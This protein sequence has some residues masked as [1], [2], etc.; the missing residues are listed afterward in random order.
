[1]AEE[2]IQIPVK[3]HEFYEMTI[4]GLGHSGEGVGRIKGFTLFV[5]L[6]L[7]S[8]K[9]RVFTEQV[10]KNYAKG[11]LEAILEPSP[12]RQT[13]PCK[14]YEACGGCQL[15]H[16]T[17]EAQLA[18]KQQVVLDAI[19]RIGKLSDVQIHPVLAAPEE[20][21]YRNKMQLPVGRKQ[22]RVVAG[23]YAQGTHAI[24]PI[25]SC[26]IQAKAN[27]Q[28]AAAVRQ[29][30]EELKIPIYDERT[31]EGVVRH[32]M[33]RYAQGTNQLMV[34]LVVTKSDFRGRDKL[35]HVLKADLPQLTSLVL[36]MNSRRTNIILGPRNKVIW[37]KP[38]IEE[39]LGNLTFKISVH[40]FFQVNTAQTEKLY[41][42]ALRYADLTGNETVLDAYCGTGTISLFLAQKAKHVIGIEVVPEAIED[43]KEN[44]KRNQITNAEFVVGDV[45]EVL[46]KLAQ[47][48]LAADVV[49]VDPPRA[50]C[51]AEML[52]TVADMRPKRIVYVSCNPSS[53][54]R[55]LARLEE[56]GYK[57]KEI[58][59]VD[60]FPQTYHVETV[61]LLQ[62]KHTTK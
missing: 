20:F 26:L 60:M 41:E 43:A 36:N 23:C 61:T 3:N 42:V 14:V 35:A 6:A 44:A 50:G 10:K 33:A 28:A 55:D 48:G 29:K 62:R 57:T 59:P 25:E 47:D 24:V 45:T 49:V 39:K 2:K 38:F 37:G 12:E 30:I 7:P 19:Q 40:S 11:R 52:E 34:V 1:M 27:N 51:S 5:P 13:A 54:A 18:A 53:L 17:A 31:G 32:I 21:H 22:G 58:Q 9:V 16:L 46:P 56:M 4:D 8:E 15:Q